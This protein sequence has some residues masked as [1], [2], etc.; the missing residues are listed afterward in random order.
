MKI[1]RKEVVHVA[2]LARL[3]LREEEIDMF[4]RQLSDI[5]TYV[6]KLSELNTNDVE[7]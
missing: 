7:P 6:E 2:K 5:L 4:A 1:S 3:A